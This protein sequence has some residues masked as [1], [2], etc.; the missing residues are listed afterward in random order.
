MEKIKAPIF[1]R[2]A[3][4]LLI[5][6]VLAFSVFW[7]IYSIA[8]VKVAEVGVIFN[9][10]VWVVGLVLIVIQIADLSGL[11]DWKPFKDRLP[12]IAVL[13]AAM[14]LETLAVERHSTL[15]RIERKLLMDRIQGLEELRRDLDPVMEQIFGDHIEFTLSI[16]KAAFT[17]QTVDLGSDLDLFKRHYK[18]TLVKFSDA[19][20]Y[21]T[22]LPY[23]RYFWTNDA[24]KM[25]ENFVNGGGKVTRIFFVTPQE[26]LDSSVRK[27]LDR[28]CEIGVQV[29][30]TN[31]EDISG[32]LLHYFLLDDQHRVGWEVWVGPDS[33][34]IR[35]VATTNRKRISEYASMWDELL[36]SPSTQPYSS[37]QNNCKH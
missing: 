35:T 24:F 7:L 15:Q 14:V 23:E 13:V 4:L 19:H 26:M 27:I 33:R 36:R 32:D 12:S 17:D 34:I 22:S 28:Q 1:L 11:L 10:G 37:G 25:M 18:R 2:F 31:R 29:F 5:S 20:L 8:D 16:A 30:T 21:A 9:Y 6:I 3:G